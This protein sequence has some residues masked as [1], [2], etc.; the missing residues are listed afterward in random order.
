MDALLDED[1]VMSTVWPVNVDNAEWE[2]WLHTRRAPP[3]QHSTGITDMTFVILRCQLARA[4]YSI[5]SRVSS[6]TATE[7]DS[8][9]ENMRNELTKSLS[10]PLSGILGQED[11]S[12]CR[13]IEKFTEVYLRLEFE[14]MR[15][16]LDV[17]HVK[18]GRRSND[19]HKNDTWHRAVHILEGL[20]HLERTS[21][22]Y[23]WSWV[24]ASAPRFFAVATILCHR[25]HRQQHFTNAEWAQAWQESERVFNLHESS[26]TD[27]REECGSWAIIKY[28]RNLA[29]DS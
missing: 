25:I 24:V 18:Y 16:A 23:G 6:L 5:L 13:P 4:L 26:L 29:R 15:L 28:W 9:V 2:A 19:E 20:A 7:T 17:S 3:P 1:E 14:Q 11:A 10:L 8:I 22:G 27:V 21:Q 12:T